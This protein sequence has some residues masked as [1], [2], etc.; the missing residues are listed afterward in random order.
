MSYILWYDPGNI[1]TIAAS[2]SHTNISLHIGTG[3]R[4][5]DTLIDLYPK[6]SAGNFK[7]YCCQR[8]FFCPDQTIAK[9][10]N[11]TWLCR[12]PRCRHLIY[13]NRSEFKLHFKYLCESYGITRKPTTVKNPLHQAS[14]PTSR[15]YVRL[16]EHANQGYKY[17]KCD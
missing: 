1:K 10:V 9:F 14:W 12:Y 7:T 5:I 6:T 13:G 15:R 16:S 2:D 11:K 3:T 4:Y 17:C 8:H